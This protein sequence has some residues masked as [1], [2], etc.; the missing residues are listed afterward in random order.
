M[1]IASALPAPSPAKTDDADSAKRK[2]GKYDIYETLGKGGYSWVK[3]GVD[4]ETGAIV[5]L[6]FMNRA[7]DKWALEQ[8]EQVRTEIKS[9]TQIRHEHVMKLYAYNL[10]AKYPLNDGTGETI[11]TILLVLEYCPG[12]ELFDILYYA[13]K[14]PEP[15]AR[16]YFQQM[17]HGL[18]A[19][20]KAGITHRDLKPQNLLLDVNFCLKITDFGLSKIMET[21]EDK[22]MKTTYV[23]TRGYQA[24]ELLKNQKYTNACDIFSIGVVLFILLAGYP[25]F[26]A[27][28]KTDKWYR[29]ITQKNWEKFWHVH[30]GAKISEEAKDLIEKMICYRPSMRVSVEDVMK[31]KWFNG[32]TVKKEALKPELL[33]R[34]AQARENRKKDA[35]K[36]KDIEDSVHRAGIKEKFRNRPVKPFSGGGQL[37]SLTTF[38]TA[39]PAY[40]AIFAVKYII[41]N[42][43]RGKVTY[44][45]EKSPD[46]LTFQLMGSRKKNT[47]LPEPDNEKPFEVAVRT[48]QEETAMHSLLHIQALRVPNH[49]VW[50]MMYR[51]LLEN[52]VLF[53]VIFSDL[54]I[55]ICE[56]KGLDC[57]TLAKR[58]TPGYKPE[59][60]DCDDNKEECDVP[61]DVQEESGESKPSES[62]PAPS[63]AEKVAEEEREVCVV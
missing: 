32:D 15:T 47:E 28:H 37:R 36:M 54:P 58:A 3:K 56:A 60:D 57:K 24:P 26:E 50:K 13:D 35:K 6:K 44:D 34:F 22:I 63:K 31:H 62:D 8:A 42:E 38:Y 27:A 5:A 40:E 20:H 16:T 7:T 21:E 49:N 4:T 14:L 19:V 2:I 1:S 46:K 61:E 10:S 30:R 59:T 29:P 52:L 33:K 25:P 18:N 39:L 51:T 12:G 48:Y 11:K 9:L 53:N 23:G 43:M 55:A 17:M 45:M 41:E